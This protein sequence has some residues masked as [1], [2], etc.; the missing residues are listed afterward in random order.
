MQVYYIGVHSLRNNKDKDKYIE[1]HNGLRDNVQ[2]LTEPQKKRIDWIAFK[3][4]RLGI[5]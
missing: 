1:L 3:L 5:L 2:F 4:L